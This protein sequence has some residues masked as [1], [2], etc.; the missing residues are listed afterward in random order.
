M[1]VQVKVDKQGRVVIP[2]RERERLGVA[3]GGILELVATAEGVLLERHRQA[4]VR[5]AG[6]DLPVISIRDF[7]PLSNEDS[8]GAI[9]RERE[10]E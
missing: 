10:R 6:D 7:E 8:V 9:H 4:D 2:L 3:D 5:I 1:A